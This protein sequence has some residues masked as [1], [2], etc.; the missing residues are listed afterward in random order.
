MPHA[1]TIS[2]SKLTTAV[3]SAVKSAIQQHPKFKIDKP[4]LTASYLIWG[5]PVP[6]PLAGT[7]NIR[8]TQSF[9][10]AVASHLGGAIPGASTEGVVLSHGGYLIVGIPV[11]PTILI[12][13]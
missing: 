10:T 11:D 7:L 8:E 1:A 13:R 4:Q 3:E 5:F 9:A 6:E 2:V 12:E